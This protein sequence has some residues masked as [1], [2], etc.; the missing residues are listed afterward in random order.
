[1]NKSSSIVPEKSNLNRPSQS[2]HGLTEESPPSCPSLES[3]NLRPRWTHNP[4]VL[5]ALACSNMGSCE[6]VKEIYHECIKSNSDS[7]VCEAAEKYYRMCQLNPS[8]E[9]FILDYNPIAE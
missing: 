8:N 1:M 4:V 2:S 9:K 7:M 6:D 5:A 3:A